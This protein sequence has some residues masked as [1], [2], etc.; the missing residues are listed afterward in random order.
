MQQAVL[1]RCSGHLDVIGEVEPAL[2]G[3]GRDAAMQE[4]LCGCLVLVRRC[5]TPSARFP[6][7]RSERSSSPK[8]ATGHRD[9]IGVVSRSF[10]CCR[11]DRSGAFSGHLVQHPGHPVETDGGA[12]KRGEVKCTH[13]RPPSESKSFFGAAF[14]PDPFRCP[15]LRGPASGIRVDTQYLGAGARGFKRC[16]RKINLYW[17]NKLRARRAA[18]GFVWRHAKQGRP[19]GAQTQDRPCRRPRT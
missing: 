18:S 15:P 11:A 8:P 7:P 13:C 10:R 9:A 16:R 17:V 14:R 4:G 5:R 12:E 19:E 3:A 6:L 2:E 1:K